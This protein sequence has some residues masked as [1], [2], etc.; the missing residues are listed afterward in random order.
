M[1]YCVAAGPKAMGPSDHGLKL[2]T[3][4]QNKLFFL[5][6]IT[7]FAWVLCHSDGKLTNTDF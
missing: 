2:E 5:L 6:K 1:M 3:I 7:Y 4:S